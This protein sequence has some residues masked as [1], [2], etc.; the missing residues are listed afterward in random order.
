MSVP[1]G[2]DLIAAASAQAGADTNEIQAS[3]SKPTNPDGGFGYSVSASAGDVRSANGDAS[4]IGDRGTLDA[5]VSSVDGQTAARVSASGALVEM[6]GGLFATR[7]PGGAV[8]LVQTG[9]AN[10]PIY[11][12]NRKV[13]DSD[14][15]GE[16]LLTNLTADAANRISIEPTDY[17]FATV[18]PTTQ[19]TVVPQRQSGV[20][21]DL[22]P[23]RSRPA[24]VI[25]E[26]D[27]GGPP[28]LG[29]SV[30]LSNGT[31]PLVVGHGGQ[32]FIADLETAVSG[33]VSNGTRSCRFHLDALD[34]APVNAIPKIG[35]IRCAAETP[36]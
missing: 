14:E 7:P 18:V 28:P 12:E 33:T 16:V 4:W 23:P 30:T 22:A 10:V 9:K 5:A 3:V 35:P 36:K 24:L 15:D 21:V 29:S 34:N 17:S 8:A 25:L 6:N 26:A 31:D 11:L 32:I 2:P 27:D 20:L 13:G 1:I 19:R